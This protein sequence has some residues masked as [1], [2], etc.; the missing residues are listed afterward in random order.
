MIG[1]NWM[2]RPKIQQTVVCLIWLGFHAVLLHLPL[3]PTQ[4]ALAR[5]VGAPLVHKP[6]QAT[7]GT[8]NHSW[9]LPWRREDTKCTR[10]TRA[11]L[12][13][14]VKH[15]LKLRKCQLAITALV[16]AWT[17]NWALSTGGRPQNDWD[18]DR[19]PCLD[20]HSTQ[21]FIGMGQTWRV[22]QTAK[23]SFGIK[24]PD[25]GSNY[26]A[27][28]H[29]SDH[30]PLDINM[31]NNLSVKVSTMSRNN[32]RYKNVY[33]HPTSQAHASTPSA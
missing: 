19:C 6:K 25:F 1:L 17:P 11:R 23:M 9:S 28:I 3:F 21:L 2:T 14:V 7:N 26:I 24:P 32:I 27:L 33:S 10:R 16:H 13:F 15:Q 5:F 18:M 12:A 31:S 4:D 22:R 30:R 8:N 29:T 20:K